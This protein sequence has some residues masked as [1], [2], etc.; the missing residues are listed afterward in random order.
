MPDFARLLDSV[1]G[2]R[3]FVSDIHGPA[4]WRQVETGGLLLARK[5]GADETVVRLFALF[6]DS[7]REND[8]ADP[9]HGP[10]GAEFA[11]Q[12]FEKGLLGVTPEQ[13]ARLHRA[14]ACHTSEP[15]SGDPTVDACYD[16]DRLDLGRV[17]LRP[18]PRRMATPAGA[19]IAR[20]AIASR[21][22]RSAMRPW[23]ASLL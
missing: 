9:A 13:F 22:P 20:R 16:A 10:R 14:C 5:T 18:E 21:I 19:A 23:L 12:C 6:H 1:L 7:R 17:G 8:G 2:N 3:L 15:R 4:H 11:R